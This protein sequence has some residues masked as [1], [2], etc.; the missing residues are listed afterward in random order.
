M[1][2]RQQQ[3][4]NRQ[5]EHLKGLLKHLNRKFLR[6]ILNKLQ[7]LSKRLSKQDKHLQNPHR[8]REIQ[9]TSS[10]LIRLKKQPLTTQDFQKTKSNSQV[11]SLKNMTDNM[12]M[13]L[14]FIMMIWSTSTK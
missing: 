9:I 12:N 11:Q 4:Q 13:T 2:N 6:K 7:I 10:A 14:S 1:I 3:A 8:H 5:M